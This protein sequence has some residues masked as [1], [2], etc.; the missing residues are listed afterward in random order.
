M[1]ETHEMDQ[2]GEMDGTNGFD[3]A[4]VFQKSDESTRGFESNP[5]SPKSTVKS[6]QSL[7]LEPESWQKRRKR[8]ERRGTCALVLHK[9]TQSQM[10]C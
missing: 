6:S 5:T 2:M 7:R 4:K 8:A 1:D 3:L 9:W 10:C